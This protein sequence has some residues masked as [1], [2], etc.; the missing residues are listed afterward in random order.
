MKHLLVIFDLD[1]TLVD[2]ER[3]CC[4]AFIDLIPKLSVSV[5]GLMLAYQGQKLA[6]IL[7][8][9]ENKFGFSLPMDFESRYRQRVDALFENELKAID[10]V[11]EMLRRV[12]FPYCIASSGPPK[13]IKKALEVTGLGHFFEERIFSS[14]SINSWKPAPLLFLHAA[15]SMGYDPADCVVIEDSSVGIEAA[16][17]AKMQWLIY[18]PLH[19]TTLSPRFQDMRD[20]PDRL[21]QLVASKPS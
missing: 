13:K 19:R 5:E 16:I 14:Y 1:G 6:D 21:Y 12:P 3:L 10:G 20:L 7:A 2:S 9:L 15:K 18:D 8:D 11:N 17:A 4:Q